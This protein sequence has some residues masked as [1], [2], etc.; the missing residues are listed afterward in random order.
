MQEE[1]DL[2]A[3]VAVEVVVAAVAG[4]VE[5]AGV[6]VE[7]EEVCIEEKDFLGDMTRALAFLL[8]FLK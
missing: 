7:G 8:L 1:A 5:G 2:G 3:A 4:A 6:D